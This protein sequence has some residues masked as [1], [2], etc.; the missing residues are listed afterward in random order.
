MVTCASDRNQVR[1]AVEL[2]LGRWPVFRSIMVEYSEDLRLPV[3]LRAD[4]AYFDRSISSKRAVESVRALSAVPIQKPTHVGGQ[5][6]DGLCFHVVI[7]KAKSM[8]RVGVLICADHALY[9]GVNIHSWAKE[10][11]Q[12]I[13]GDI[14]RDLTP[15]KMFTN[16]YQLYQDSQPAR[17]AQEYYRQHVQRES[18]SP[19]TSWPPGDDLSWYAAAAGGAA[20]T[21]FKRSLDDPGFETVILWRMLVARWSEYGTVPT[22]E[23]HTPLAV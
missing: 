12:I 19:N 15:Y 4:R 5:L 23:W 9:D 7:A 2:S 17:R 1:R 16:A 6:A 20:S 3:A 22:W 14:I 10:L 13:N 11:N 18:V 21:S 8:E